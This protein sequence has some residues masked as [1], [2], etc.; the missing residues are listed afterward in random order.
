MHTSKQTKKQQNVT[1]YILSK[2]IHLFQQ[3]ETNKLFKV[4]KSTQKSQKCNKAYPKNNDFINFHHHSYS[5]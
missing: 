5:V 4:Q 1:F 2:K 3:N